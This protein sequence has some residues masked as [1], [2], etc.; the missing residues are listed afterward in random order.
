M[1]EYPR[2]FYQIAS[3]DERYISWL[4]DVI[5]FEK[6]KDKISPFAMK[7]GYLHIVY[8]QSMKRWFS[9]LRLFCKVSYGKNTLSNSD[10]IL[11]CF[12]TGCHGNKEHYCHKRLSKILHELNDVPSPVIDISQNNLE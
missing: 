1:E 6:G 5:P 3:Y 11:Q 12:E 7:D 9:I 4:I 10:A 8:R 2:A